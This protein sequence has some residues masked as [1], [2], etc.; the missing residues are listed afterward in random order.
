MRAVVIAV[1]VLALLWSGYWFGA[2]YVTERAATDMLAA[3]PAGGTTMGHDGLTVTGYPL[4]FR[5]DAKR[6]HMATETG[7]GWSAPG[8]TVQA[9]AWR[10]WQVTLDLPGQ[11]D[12]TLPDQDLSLASS[13]FRAKVALQPSMTLALAATEVQA[14]G[15]SVLSTQDWTLALAR[16]TLQSRVRADDPLTHDVTLRANSL[17]PDEAFR[18]R[19]APLSAL[20]ELV[21]SLTLDAALT[22]A[23]PLD[24]SALKTEPRLTAVT[25]SNTEVVWG[26]LV[27]TAKGTIAPG[28]DGVAEGRIDL[29]IAGWRN[30]PAVLVASGLMAEDFAPR[31]TAALGVLAAKG[32]PTPAEVLETALV[33]EKGYMQF[34]P[35]PL[36]P[37]PRLV[38]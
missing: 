33:M 36:G 7:F 1:A 32:G 3:Q 12:I 21:D 9:A 8:A 20:P 22:F 2:A 30:L 18:R 34:G 17:T 25:L 15:L 29:T 13:V 16:L 26:E 35:L 31:L 19:L 14:D 23:A 28:A 11:Q 37:A 24:L 4:N 27:M 5:L 6:P 10:P 38:D